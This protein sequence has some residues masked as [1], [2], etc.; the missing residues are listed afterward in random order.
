MQS[1]TSAAGLAAPPRNDGLLSFGSSLGPVTRARLQRSLCVYGL[2]LS[3][4]CFLQIGESDEIRSL[5]LGLAAPGAGFLLWVANAG[6]VALLPAFAAAGLFALSLILWFG[7]GNVVLPPAIWLGSAFAA[8]GAGAWLGGESD[9]SGKAMLIGLPLALGLAALTAWLVLRRLPDR[10]TSVSGYAAQPER[11]LTDTLPRQLPAELDS[12]T[13]SLMSLVL[14]RAQQP[15]DAF[16]GFEWRDQFQTAAI[17]YQLNF[18]SYALAMVQA[19]HLPASGDYL[20]LAQDNLLAKLGD[21]R[22]WRYWALE[23]AWGRLRLAADPVPV[24]NIMYSG[25]AAAQIVFARNA[26][27]PVGALRL[28]H[29]RADRAR[30]PIEILIEILTRQYR[31]A[32]FGLLACEPNWIYPLCN[33]ITAAAIKGH[34]AQSGRADWPKIAPEFRHGLVTEF[35][36]ATGD[37]VPFRSSLTGIAPPVLGGAVMQAFPSFF[38]NGLFPDLAAMQWERLRA[39]LAR[40][41]RARAFWPI[42]VGNYG[43][44]RASSYAASAA[45]AVEMGDGEIAGELLSALD[46]ECPAVTTGGARHRSHASLWAHALELMARAGSTNGLR[47]LLS[48]PAPSGAGPR[49]HEVRHPDILVARAIADGDRLDATFH[50]GACAGRTSIGL[51]GLEPGRSYSVRGALTPS[52]RSDELGTATLEL[53]LDGR[54]ELSVAPAA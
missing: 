8:A 3:L 9:E 26:G 34:D 18:L 32:P 16:E 14:D 1:K 53:I 17:R 30:Y 54:T 42:D 24:D 48:T 29:P 6:W 43:F 37:I 13:L 33:A 45:A 46:A 40:Q 50:P 36:T 21:H 19:N 10:A 2:V 44:S 47:R 5:G 23:N 27:N 12:D 25:F 11:A 22:V 35:M 31:T 38:L 52:F 41:D 39:R 20:S 7:T 51:A 15:I 28:R 4:A 49:L